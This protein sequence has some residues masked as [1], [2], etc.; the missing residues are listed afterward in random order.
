MHGVMPCQRRFRRVMRRKMRGIVQVFLAERGPQ[1]EEYG[2]AKI[3]RQ[4]V[5]AESMVEVLGRCRPGP[6]EYRPAGFRLCSADSAPQRRLDDLLYFHE[7]H[8]SS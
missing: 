2:Q 6:P 4:P 5:P 3:L 8:D 1:A 7:F